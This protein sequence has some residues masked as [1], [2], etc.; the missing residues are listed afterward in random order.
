MTTYKHYLGNNFEYVA[1]YKNGILV[2]VK[3]RSIRK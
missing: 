2:A 3:G 1:A